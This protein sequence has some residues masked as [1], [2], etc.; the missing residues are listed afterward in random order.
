MMLPRRSIAYAF[1]SVLVA[2]APALTGARTVAAAPSL[3]LVGSRIT[4]RL[5]HRAARRA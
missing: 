3:N 1:A 5:Q 4:A 2:L